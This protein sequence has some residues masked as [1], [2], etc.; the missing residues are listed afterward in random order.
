M[1]LRG[2]RSINLHCLAVLIISICITVVVIF[3][4]HVI[5][6]IIIY[7]HFVYTYPFSTV[8]FWKD[9]RTINK[10]PLLS[11]LKVENVNLSDAT[12]VV[13]A[14]C[15]NVK[16]NLVGFQR[17]VQAI[18]RLFGNYRIYLG[19]SD[20]Q[21]GTLNFLYEWQK[22]DSDHVRVHTKGQQRWHVFSRKFNE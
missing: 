2:R 15:R 13:T 21:D 20:S 9:N 10:D 17:N 8:P 4:I 12:I 3:I 14:C 16:K 1:R 19:E 7:N 5:Y 11:V 22:N 18:T 6:I